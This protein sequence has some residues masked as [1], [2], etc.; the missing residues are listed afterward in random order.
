VTT[1]DG[2]VSWVIQVLRESFNRTLTKAEATEYTERYRAAIRRYETDPDYRAHIAR[3]IAEADADLDAER[4]DE[5]ALA[6]WETDGAGP[7]RGAS[8]G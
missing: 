6:R 5:L 1:D 7:P 4:Q 8:D 2:D 3:L